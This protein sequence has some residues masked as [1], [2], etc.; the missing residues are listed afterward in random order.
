L[1]NTGAGSDGIVAFGINATDVSFDTG[2][3][4]DV[5]GVYQSTAV[6]LAVR[7]GSGDEGNGFYGVVVGTCTVTGLLQVDSGDGLDNVLL[8]SVI[9]TSASI[10]TGT[11]SDG[12]IVLFCDITTATFNTSDAPDV[13]GVYD[14]IFDDLTILLGSGVDD[15]W[16]GN[17]TT[18]TSASLQGELNGGKLHR[19]G[20][21]QVQGETVLNLTVV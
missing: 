6:N 5:I 13:V 19:L 1:V 12:L 10:L 17:L 14:S 18:N 8:G 9:A 11:G 15:L 2:S 20:T 4:P 7:T 21:N 3:E 16:Y